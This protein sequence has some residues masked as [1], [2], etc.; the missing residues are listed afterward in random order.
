MS[1]TIFPNNFLPTWSGK[2]HGLPQQLPSWGKM[3]RQILKSNIVVLTNVFMMSLL[4]TLESKYNL[5]SD[6]DLVSGFFPLSV[7]QN[8]PRGSKIAD[9]KSK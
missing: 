3:L 8:W 6:R 7:M 9:K 4:M 2:K 5:H 1:E